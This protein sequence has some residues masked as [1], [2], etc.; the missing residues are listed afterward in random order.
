M[1]EFEVNWHHVLVCEA[2]DRFVSGACKRLIV[3]MPP[4]HSKSEL[5][6]RR[7]PAF[8]FGRNPNAQ[9]MAT[10]YGADLAARMN[11]DVQRIIDA[12]QYRE[13]FPD[14]RLYGENVRTVA[15]GSYLRNSD[16]F[17]IVGHKGSYRGA[18]VGGGIVGMGFHYGIIDDPIK[19]R[20]EADSLT[21]RNNVWE[22]YTSTFYTRQEK[23]AAI[24]ITMT[25]WHEDDLVGRL[26][27]QA[28]SDPNAD[29]W[30]VI[31]LPALAEDPYMV[32]DPRTDGQA[33]WPGKYDETALDTMR[34]TVGSYEWNAQYQCRPKAREGNLLQRSW[35]TIVDAAPALGRWVRYWDKAGT[36]AGGKKTA[37]VL[38]CATPDGLYYVVDVVTG[39]WSAGERERVIKQTA[40]LDAA[41]FDSR[42]TVKI[43]A[44][45]E[46][47][48]GGKESAEATIRMLA[49]YPVYKEPATGDKVTRGEP[50]AAQAEVGNVRLVRGDWNAA[51]VEELCAVPNGTFW[52]QFDATSGAF[53]KLATPQGVGFG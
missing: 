52:D 44:E 27:A 24:L 29:Q 25:P 39:Q 42:T 33:L 8:I 7:L 2:L 47:G 22:W 26:L 34:A 38:M 10:S 32:G 31:R 36:E 21:F 46:P 53:N 30:D 17:E 49:G 50:F 35:F 20:A 16:I 28:K 19:N 40:E 11:R 9:I 45:Q 51:Y 13:L 18:G 4:R 48:S 14:T 3:L 5:V 6:S 37:G 15:K 43:W 12:P 1:P 23:N 41:R